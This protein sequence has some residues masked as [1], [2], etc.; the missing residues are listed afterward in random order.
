MYTK[1]FKFHPYLKKIFLFFCWLQ[2]L[3]PFL[4]SGSGS[5]LLVPGPLLVPAPDPGSGPDDL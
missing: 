5:F 1:V 4:G 2:V 3:A